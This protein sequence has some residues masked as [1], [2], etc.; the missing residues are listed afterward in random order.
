ML[1]GF[2]N[3][4]KRMITDTCSSHIKRVYTRRI[5]R[6]SWMQQTAT[7]LHIHLY[8][9]LPVGETLNTALMF[10]FLPDQV[11]GTAVCL[12]HLNE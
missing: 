8:Y 12:Y 7:D 10:L 4:A 11:A 5:S 3:W 1:Y 9:R 6:Y 2:G